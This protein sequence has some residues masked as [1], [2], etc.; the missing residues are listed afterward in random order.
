[1]IY[2][3]KLGNGYMAK[4]TAMR[5]DKDSRLLGYFKIEREVEQ[6]NRIRL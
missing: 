1:M 4:L 6:G 2:A 3:R 5:T